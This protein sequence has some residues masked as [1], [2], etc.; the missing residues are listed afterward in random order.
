M[1]ILHLISSCGFYGAEAMLVTLTKALRGAGHEATIGLLRTAAPG[2]LDIADVARSER[3]PIEVLPCAGRWD[4]S[5][6]RRIQQVVLDTNVN[7]VHLH[8]YKADMY[9]LLATRNSGTKR[10]ATCHDSGMVKR[11]HFSSPSMTDLYGWVDKLTLRRFHC[12]AAVSKPIA[13]ALVR[14]GVPADRVRVIDNGIDLQRFDG[15]KPAADLLAFKDNAPLIGLVGRLVEGK[16][17]EVLLRVT[18]ELALLYPSLKIVFVGDGPLLDKLQKLTYELGLTPR[19]RFAGKRA[20]MPS[21][22]AA[23]DIFVLP[24]SNEG[25]PISILEAMCSS[26]PVVASRVG[27]IP[28]VIADRQTGLLVEPGDD[29]SLRA[30]ITDLLSSPTLRPMLSQNASRFVRSNYSSGAM[31]T[32]YLHLYTETLRKSS[33]TQYSAVE[34][35]SPTEGVTHE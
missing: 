32:K 9:G 16:G 33:T 3:L 35:S 18:Q 8:G 26:T 29:A 7:L 4:S 28:S 2:C 25:M 11:F 19:V 6:V 30:A 12:V 31:A 1:K 22:Y 5:A 24:S 10:I 27:A 17:H 15:S 20:D 23:L 13:E 21:V 14:S 34:T